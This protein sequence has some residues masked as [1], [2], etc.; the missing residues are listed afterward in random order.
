[1]PAAWEPVHGHIEPGE[2]P[3]DAALRELREETGLAADRLYIVRVQPFY[4]Q[5]R[6]RCSSRSS[7]PRSWRS[8]A[9]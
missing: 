9:R 2:E 4:L 3:E 1:M 5:R 7:S 6:A 8:R